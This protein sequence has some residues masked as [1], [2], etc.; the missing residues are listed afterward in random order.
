M[1]NRFDDA[2]KRAAQQTDQELQN[3]ICRLS[4]L[5]Q[6]DI[7]TLFPKREDQ[8]KLCALIQAV[9]S[10]TDENSQLIAFREK[11]GTCASIA[12]RLVKKFVKPL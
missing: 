3:E 2:S 8:E 4:L 1:G 11:M 10:A 9:N 7:T 6:D 12:L 5:S